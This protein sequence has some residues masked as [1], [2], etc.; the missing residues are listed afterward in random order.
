MDGQLGELVWPHGHEACVALTFD[1]DADVG[2]GWRGIA[3]RLTARSEARYGA[4]RG[5]PRILETLRRRDLRATFYVPGEIA[6]LHPDLVRA[7]AADGHEIGHHGHLHLWTDRASAQEQRE[8]VERGL[9]ALER[10]GVPRPAGFRSPAWELTPETLALLVEHGFR[11]DSSCMGDDRPY[12]E[13]HGDH[14]I[15]ELPVHWSLDDWVW[16]GF[17]RDGGGLMSAPDALERTWLLELE[18]ALAERRMVTYTMHPECMGRGYRMRMLE[19]MLDAMAAQGSV[20]FATHG[21]VAG[22]VL[23]EA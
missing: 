9:E 18:S 1:V 7:I 23:G 13:V 16:F 19:R 15:L 3:E 6:E 8:E 21:E 11:W 14:R 12:E 10:C 4:V 2:L 17:S 5:M 22:L 20:W